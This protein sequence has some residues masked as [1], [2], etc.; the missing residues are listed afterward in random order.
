MKKR[1]IILGSMVAL[2]V[3]VALAAVLLRPPRVANA[4]VTFVSVQ[5]TQGVAIRLGDQPLGDTPFQTALPPGEYR[6]MA[7]L[8]GYRP[9]T[10]RFA[11]V[12][13]QPVEVEIP[14][15]DPLGGA[16][17]VQCNAPAQLYVNGEAQGMCSTAAYAS[18]GRYERGTYT[19]RAE[20]PLEIQE[21]TAMVYDTVDAQL[22]FAWDAQLIV[23][24]EPTTATAQVYVDGKPVQTPYTIPAKVIAAKAFVQVEV[25]AEGYLRWAN[26]VFV[27]PGEKF[28]I[29]VELEPAPPATPIPEDPADPATAVLAAYWHCWAVYLQSYADLD[30]APLAEVLTG[31]LLKVEQDNI[32]GLAE[33]GVTT[34][35]LTYT[36]HVPMIELLSEVTASVQ[37]AYD[38]TETMTFADG[39]ENTMASSWQ[40]T[41]TFV[42]EADGVWRAAAWT[43]TAEPAPTPAPTPGGGGPAPTPAP[44]SS[45]GGGGGQGQAADRGLVAQIIVAAINCGR[46]SAGF[47]PL[48]WDPEIAAA[49][50]PVVEAET[51]FYQAHGYYDPSF[52]AQE[53]AALQPLGAYMLSGG[54]ICLSYSPGNAKWGLFACDWEN[55]V[56]KPCATGYADSWAGRPETASF[57]RIGI[58]IGAPYWDG[59]GWVATI[60]IAAR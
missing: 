48:A 1:W 7:S 15:L 42:R 57:T 35:V 17:L 53:D 23:A 32:A 60:L 29:E 5:P 56:D 41:F 44:T 58:A 55:Y 39:Q 18:L 26:D 10:G 8:A 37:V 19:V 46:Q 12:E 43:A 16:I 27:P 25:Q 50:A 54:G 9:Y 22:T 38:Q 4:N 47:A 34:D 21:Q 52:D 30:P 33:W 31:E 45:G 28:T 40:G 11:V 20:M 24:V 14:P 49:L 13:G 3:V 36:A 59:V 6:Y 51:R 2:V